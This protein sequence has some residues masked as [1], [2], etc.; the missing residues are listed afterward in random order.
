MA[1]EKCRK[2]EKANKS[3]NSLTNTKSSSCL[4]RDLFAS[5]EVTTPHKSKPKSRKFGLKKML[6]SRMD[7]Q[8]TTKMHSGFKENNCLDHVNRDDCRLI[9]AHALLNMGISHSV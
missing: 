5:K 1:K 7:E 6:I 3:E 8:I 9:V 2:A 4:A